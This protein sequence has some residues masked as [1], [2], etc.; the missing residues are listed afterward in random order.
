MYPGGHTPAHFG[1]KA[2]AAGHERLPMHFHRWLTALI[3]L[4]LLVLVLLKGGHLFFVLVLLL[5]NGLALWEFLGM[6]LPETIHIRRFKA[7]LM[8]TILLLS[9]CTG[10][11]LLWCNPIGPL[12]VLVGL[13]F[14]LFLFYLLAYEQVADVS[15]DLMVNTLALL[16]LPLLLGHFIWLRYLPDGQW[17][18][19]WALAVVMASDTAALYVGTALGRRKLY[20]SVSPGKTWAGTV[21]G[22]IAGVMAGILL[23]FW[24]LPRIGIL[25]LYWL[26]LGVSLVG[27]LGDLFE[28]LLK[29][30]AQVKDAS[31]LLPG[32]GGMLDRLDSLLFVAPLVVYVR[33]LL[34]G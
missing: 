14:V 13:L 5:V 15:R 1:S 19:L 23:G 17:W 10:Q 29:R 9:F 22:M 26:A 16:Y 34:L 25:P 12:M 2:D 24:L 30:Q 7:I 3:I 8:G 6:F 28:S 21:G 18:V 11:K 4:P 20:P 27:V 33:L 31:K 32:H